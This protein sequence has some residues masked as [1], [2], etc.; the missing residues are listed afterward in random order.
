MS[1][2]NSVSLP[3]RFLML[4]AVAAARTLV[5][6]P[7][8]FFLMISN[9]NSVSL[10]GFPA[11]L[12]SAWEALLK[13]EPQADGS[14]RAPM[15][16]FDADELVIRAID[17]GLVTVGDNNPHGLATVWLSSLL[18]RS[19][20]QLA[21][22]KQSIAHKEAAEAS[23]A[24]SSASAKETEKEQRRQ[25]RLR[26][27]T[28]LGILPDDGSRTSTSGTPVPEAVRAASTAPVAASFTPDWQPGAG[29]D[30]IGLNVSVDVVATK[31]RII[32]KGG[33]S[34]FSSACVYSLIIGVAVRTWQHRCTRC[35]IRIDMHGLLFS[36][37]Y[38]T[39][40]Y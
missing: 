39:N 19:S 4:A 28:K 23:A 35:D 9:S 10:A 21:L 2:Y 29:H 8:H 3:V 31:R 15:A 36:S 6:H 30:V 20:E 5:E 37:G 27:L 16:L 14:T 11:S 18:S 38:I 1:I 7:L 13:P 25:E 22:L 40:C 12:Q 24:A 33:S 17:S 34:T 26:A 32:P